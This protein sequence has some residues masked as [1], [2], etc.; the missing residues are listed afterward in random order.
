MNNYK[1][2]E[3]VRLCFKKYISYLETT[4]KINIPPN[5][6]NSTEL[7]IEEMDKLAQTLFM[8]YV[9]KS[10]EKINPTAVPCV[11]YKHVNTLI[12]QYIAEEQKSKPVV[13][14]KK[15]WLW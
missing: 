5:Q 13:Q 15:G 10:S 12:R 7:S 1:I 8:D 9:V 14:K 4:E 2:L 3:T 11:L 6:T